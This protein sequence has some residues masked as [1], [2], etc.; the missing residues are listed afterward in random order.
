MNNQVTITA[1]IQSA[2]IE[3]MLLAYKSYSGNASAT[4]DEFFEFLTLPTAERE[5][6]LQYQCACDYQVQGSIVI[7]NYQVK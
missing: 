4:S 1:A 6:F 3:Q 7:P 5:A 2:S